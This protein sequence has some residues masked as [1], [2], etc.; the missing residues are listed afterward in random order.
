[1][2]L[3]ESRLEVLINLRNKLCVINKANNA[4]KELDKKRVVLAEDY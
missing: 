3:S 2:I 1:M 4:D